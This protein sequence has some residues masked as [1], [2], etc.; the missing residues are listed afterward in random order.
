MKRAKKQSGIVLLFTVIMMFLLAGIVMIFVTMTIQQVADAMAGVRNAQALNLAE[1]GVTDAI[2][3]VTHSDY[4]A[5]TVPSPPPPAERGSG[6]GWLGDGGTV[7]SPACAYELQDIT[8]S[9]PITIGQ[10]AILSVAPTGET[11]LNPYV[12]YATLHPMATFNPFPL[13]TT[14]DINSRLEIITVGYVPS[15]D[16]P[17]AKKVIKAIAAFSE[18][19]QIRLEGWSEV[20]E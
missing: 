15:V 2:W 5:P 11:I 14:T 7:I 1:T 13:A 6:Y 9:S 10:Y 4:L 3:Y 20:E 12:Q 17:K 8:G 19:G 16:N 18:H